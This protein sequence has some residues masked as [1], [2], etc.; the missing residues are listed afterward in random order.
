MSNLIMQVMTFFKL[1][2]LQHWTFRV[3]FM[4]LL[5]IS[6]CNGSQ[7]YWMSERHRFSQ[8]VAFVQENLLSIFLSRNSWAY[9]WLEYRVDGQGSILRMVVNFFCAVIS[10]KAQALTQMPFQWIYWR[11]LRV[12]LTVRSHLVPRSQEQRVLLPYT[13]CLHAIAVLRHSSNFL[14]LCVCREEVFNPVWFVWWSSY[15]MLP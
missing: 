8:R 9:G 1:N 15:W 14:F 4:K 10:K 13:L 5:L 7:F 3:H 11:N 6:N 2:Y 12:K